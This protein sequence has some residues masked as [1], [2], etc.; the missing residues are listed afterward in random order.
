MVVSGK[1]NLKLDGGRVILRLA[2]VVFAPPAPLRPLDHEVFVSGED[3]FGCGRLDIKLAQP[4]WQ[5]CHLS[6]EMVNTT[7]GS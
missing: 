1:L 4:L 2:Q 5:G 6:T 7:R 3:V